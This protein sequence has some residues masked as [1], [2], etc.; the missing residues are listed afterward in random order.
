MALADFF[1][2]PSSEAPSEGGLSPD[3]ADRLEQ[4]KA[5]YLKQYGKPMPITSGFRT[6]EQQQR[7]FDQR[8]L[9]PNL[10]AQPGTSLHETGNAVDIGTT[11]PEEFLNQFGIHRPLGAKDPVHAVLMPTGAPSEGGLASFFTRREGEEAP[12]EA[13]LTKPYIG[14]RPMRSQA[15]I[16]AQKVGSPE[17][18]QA[19]QERD[20]E[21]SF[22]RDLALGGASL[23]DQTIGGV[24]P[25]A[26][27]V[28]Q[29]GARFLGGLG[30]AITGK[31]S[32]MTPERAA[33]LGG[34][35][36]SALEKPFGKTLGAFGVGQ[37][38]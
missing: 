5:A 33:Q 2:R 19:N 26:G 11:V 17:A 14:Y 4:A 15:A 32:G 20:K 31:P 3:L 37:G 21:T 7:L 35:V 28:T 34:A 10:V 23:A 18:Q 13:D 6:K 8:K 9:N 36:T 24:L 29:A 12:K 27:Q 38:K 1:T 30:E 16:Q 22:L 25:M